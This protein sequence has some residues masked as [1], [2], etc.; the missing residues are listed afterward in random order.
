MTEQLSSA[1]QVQTGLRP[2]SPGLAGLLSPPTSSLEGPAKRGPQGFKPR[3]AVGPTWPR[4]CSQEDQRRAQNCSG[5]NCGPISCPL[6]CSHPQHLSQPTE[7]QVRMPSESVAWLN[8]ASY[9]HLGWHKVPGEPWSPQSRQEPVTMLG[10][11]QLP[12]PTQDM[13][14]PHACLA[15]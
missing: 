7:S 8:G 12:V 11:T 5:L 4:A 13:T 10:W 9:R 14:C 6:S 1:G 2:L 3:A 15:I